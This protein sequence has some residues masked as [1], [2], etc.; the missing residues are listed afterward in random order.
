MHGLTGE[1]DS[2]A[3]DEDSSTRDRDSSVGLE[4][5]QREWVMNGDSL[6]RD[7]D[8]SAGEGDNSGG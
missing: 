8:A 5:T 3:G 2:S 7:G 1:E 6:N 4:T